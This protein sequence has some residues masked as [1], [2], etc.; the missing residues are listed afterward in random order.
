MRAFT[1]RGP[2]WSSS[3]C[4]PLHRL[5]STWTYNILIKGII[6]INYLTSTNDINQTKPFTSM[7]YD[8]TISQVIKPLASMTNHWHQWQHDPTISPFGIDGN[9]NIDVNTN[10]QTPITN[11][12]CQHVDKACSTSIV[13]VTNSPYQSLPSIDINHINVIISPPLTS[14]EKGHSPLGAAP[15]SKFLWYS[16][17]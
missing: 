16:S 9:T 13:N 11:Y 14:M 12:W 3:I 2:L 8:P 10:Y 5:V 15:L 4:L 6:S 17:E 1:I 7:T